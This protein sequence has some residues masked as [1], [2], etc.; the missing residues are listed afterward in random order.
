MPSSGESLCYPF[1]LLRY[2]YEDADR[3]WG[4]NDRNEDGWISWE[5]Y[6]NAFVGTIEGNSNTVTFIV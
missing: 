4:D 1:C 3:Q 5:E 2:I 6:K